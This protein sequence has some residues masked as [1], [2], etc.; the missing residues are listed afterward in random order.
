MWPKI[1]IYYKYLYLTLDVN[2]DS[3]LFLH[4]KDIFI[5]TYDIAKAYEFR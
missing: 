5:N 1:H 2:G 4:F 3:D